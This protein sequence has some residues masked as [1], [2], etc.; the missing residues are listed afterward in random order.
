VAGLDLHPGYGHGGSR[1]LV[2][3]RQLCQRVE[4][5]ALCAGDVTGPRGDT[6]SHPGDAALVRRPS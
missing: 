4:L 2:R 5:D 6:D 1:L 3:V